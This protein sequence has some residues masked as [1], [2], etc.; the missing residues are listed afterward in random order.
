MHRQAQV[1][2]RL[3]GHKTIIEINSSIFID[4]LNGWIMIDEGYGDKYCHAQ[5]NY[6]SKGLRD[7]NGIYNY[8][9]HNGHIV[10]LTKEEKENLYPIIIS[11]DKLEELDKRVSNLETL[12]NTI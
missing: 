3:D 7:V 6:L 11:E 8:K 1:Y 4:D 12:H 5:G 2:I 9:Y 10:E